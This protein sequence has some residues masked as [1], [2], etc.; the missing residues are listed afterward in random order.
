MTVRIHETTK[1]S[2]WHHVRTVQNDVNSTTLRFHQDHTVMCNTG[3]SGVWKSVSSCVGRR[4]RRGCCSGNFNRIIK[5]KIPARRPPGIVAD[6]NNIPARHRIKIS[7]LS[8]RTGIELITFWPLT[9]SVNQWVSQSASQSVSQS[10]RKSV[11]QSVNSLRRIRSTSEFT[12][13]VN[14]TPF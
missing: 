7:A 6:S 12:W 5:K 2:S 10:V 3:T 1:L 13:P 9:Q 11:S 14:S 8:R 4:I